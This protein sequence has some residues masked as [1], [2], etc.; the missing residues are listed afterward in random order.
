MSS[1]GAASA[2]PI[3]H[4]FFILPITGGR[5]RGMVRAAAPGLF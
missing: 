5:A 2:A 3:P 1:I 4:N